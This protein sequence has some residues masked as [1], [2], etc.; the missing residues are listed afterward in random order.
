MR[1][2]VTQQLETEL[3]CLTQQGFQPRRVLKA[4][5]LHDDTVDAL[6]LFAATCE[7]FD[8]PACAGTSLG[9][10]SVTSLLEDD[11][12]L[13]NP[14]TATVMVPVGAEEQM[15]LRRPVAKARLGRVWR[16]LGDDPTTLP[17]KH[18]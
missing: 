9:E 15:G 2:L 3:G 10:S 17:Q 12:G 8:A 13:W 1:L 18:E 16:V 11:G 4:R 6:A 14:S 7:Y 5:Y